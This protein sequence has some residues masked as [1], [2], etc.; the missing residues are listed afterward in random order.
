MC[1]RSIRQRVLGS[2]TIRSASMPGNK[3]PLPDMPKNL[4]GSDEHSRTTLDIDSRPLRAAE[5]I[6]GSLVSTPGSPG[7][8]PVEYEAWTSFCEYPNHQLCE[9]THDGPCTS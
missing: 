1:S 6:N 9:C 5:S 8:V 3:E 2:T 7:G 4:A